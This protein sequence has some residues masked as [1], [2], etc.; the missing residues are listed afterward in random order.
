MKGY[1]LFSLWEFFVFLFSLFLSVFF[2]LFYFYGMS[3]SFTNKGIRLLKEQ[4]LTQAQKYFHKA[5]DEK[6]FEPWPYINLALNYDL[7][8]KESKALKTYHIV[9]SQLQ[10][11]SGTAL[12]Y[13]SFNLGELYGRLGKVSQ[14]LQ[15]Y[16]SA[17]E[18]QYKE[19][20]IKKNIELLFQ[21]QKKNP[22][23]QQKESQSN[24]DQEK[25]KE[26]EQGQSSEQ[27]KK[28]ESG[29][30]EQDK[31]E[32]VQDQNTK[33]EQDGQNKKRDS[34][35]GG[36]DQKDSAQ[37]Q[38]SANKG[39]GFKELSDKEEQAIFEEVEKQENSVRSKFY[40]MKNTFG[41]KTKED[42]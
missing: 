37:D 27:N 31:Q 23:Q 19:K 32:S 26:Q 15:N 24:A 35:E 16:Q 1:P 28:N 25:N 33:E 39:K 36:Q 3:Y 18:F 42:W 40:Q 4:K 17:L 20:D 14:A 30:E 5:L 6:P 21:D 41:D 22:N 11:Q 12:F 2:V 7:L 9:P 29:K 38:E 34:K 13:T 10:S 8:K